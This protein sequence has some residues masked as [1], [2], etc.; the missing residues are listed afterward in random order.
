M[1]ICTSCGNQRDL[2]EMRAEGALSCCPERNMV[3]AA[4]LVRA[5]EEIAGIAEGS[6]TAN[7][8]PHIAKIARASL[9]NGI[10]LALQCRTCRGKRYVPADPVA[11][12]TMQI[13]A[14]APAAHVYVPCP[15]CDGQTN[16]VCGMG[17]CV[18]YCPKC[19]RL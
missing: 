4:G 18:D 11:K 19:D 3:E 14:W 5:I 2:E 10:P 12:S 16:H 1:M 9:R 15:K 13:K 17:A 8:L 7:S 6:T